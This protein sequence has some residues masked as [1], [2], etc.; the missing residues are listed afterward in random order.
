MHLRKKPKIAI[1]TIRNNYNY[2]GVLSCLKVV[3]SFCQRYFD[4]KVF[5]LGFDHEVATSLRALKFISSVKPLSYFG[6]NCIEIG[7]RWSFWEPGHYFFTS[8]TWRQ[9]LKNYDYFFVVSGSCIAAH[10][11]I[12]LNKKF[13]MWVGT[14]HTEDRQERIKQLTGL[15]YFLHLMAHGRMKAIE[16]EI[17]SQATA[18]LA[19]STYAKGKF[20]QIIGKPKESITLCGFPMDCIRHPVAA[21]KD[22]D[23]IIIMAVGRFSD[24]RKNVTMLLNVFDKVYARNQH[25]KLYVVGKKPEPDTM[26][27]FANHTSLVNV[28]FTGQI[29]KDDLEALY[30]R[31]HLFLITS[32]QEGLGIVG[33]EAL[34]HG[35]PVVATDCGGTRDY[36]IDGISGYLVAINDS[37]DMV[38]KICMI[39][40]NKQL[41]QHL[42]YNGRKLIE[43]SFSFANTYTLFKKALCDT[44]PNLQAWFEECDHQKAVKENKAKAH[45]FQDAV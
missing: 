19:I 25:I 14:P 3:H 43:E 27:A 16:K 31:A 37:D 6:M 34:L 41:Y 44:Y 24:P 40:S 9:L 4:S 8:E 18:T 13:V 20:E 26:A 23:E 28:T 15:R 7:A 32:H 33:L 5:F 1:I 38:A 21:E 30:D 36:V 12:V 22:F 35:I 29:T 11:L 42:S 17:L 2:G 39:L 10:P 45:F